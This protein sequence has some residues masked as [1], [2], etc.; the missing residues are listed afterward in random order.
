MFRQES[1]CFR[2]SSARSRWNNARG[3]PMDLP[4]RVPYCFARVSPA[5]TRSEIRTRSCL[6]RQSL[7]LAGFDRQRFDGRAIVVGDAAGSHEYDDVTSRKYLGPAMGRFA[8]LEV[9]QR[10]RRAARGW[11]PHEYGTRVERR[12]NGAILSPIRSP[13]I[14]SVTEGEGRATLNPE[15]FSPC[16]GIRT[17]E[18]SGAAASDGRLPVAN[19]GRRRRKQLGD[20]ERSLKF[21]AWLAAKNPRYCTAT[22][23]FCWL[24]VLVPMVR[25]TGCEPEPIFVGTVASI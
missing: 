17:S 1:P 11:Y 12:D 25:T 21:V 19:F 9:G 24:L 6:A 13:R 23:M 18:R 14:R 3:L 20:G 5:R 22:V 2:S 16:P 8:R 10:L 7:C 4:L 15:S